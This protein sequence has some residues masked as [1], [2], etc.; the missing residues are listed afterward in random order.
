MMQKKSKFE[1]FLALEASA[2]SGK[3]FALSVRFVAI[4][5]MGQNINNILALTFTNKAAKEMK[6]RIV[7]LFVGL[8]KKENDEYLY[9]GELE[10]LKKLLG[11]DDTAQ[12]IALRDKY[13]D[14]FL[15]EELRVGTFDSF[16]IKILRSFAPNVGLSPDFELCNDNDT[17]DEFLKSLDEHKC[18]SLALHLKWFNL[19]FDS[20]YSQ[21]KTYF[22]SGAKDIKFA[23]LTHKPDIK[24]AL[25]NLRVVVKISTEKPLQA[26]HLHNSLDK[27][28]DDFSI[29]GATFLDESKVYV[30][31]ALEVPSFKKAFDELKAQMLDFAKDVFYN[32]ISFVGD[33]I[34]VFLT[35][36][37]NQIKQTNTLSFSDVS[38]KV[39]SL[40]QDERFKE[41]LNFRLNMQIDHLL[42]DEFQDTNIIQFNILKPLASEILSGVGV[43][44]SLRSLF[45]VGDKKQSIYRFRGGN[46]ETF[47]AFRQD[48]NGEFLAQIKSSS[49]DTNYRS[50]K[51]IV[52][53]VND[54]FSKLYG[55][56]GVDFEL[57]KANKEQDGC[58]KFIKSS[59]DESFEKCLCVINELM[60]YN[61]SLDDI[62]ILTRKNKTAYE[63]KV[64][65]EQNGIKATTKG[66]TL[67]VNE[68]SVRLLLE[69]AKWCVFGD[70]A[71]EEFVKQSIKGAKR[72]KVSNFLDYALNPSQTYEICQTNEI[73]QTSDICPKNDESYINI[74]EN[75][76][77]VY[78]KMLKELK[79][80]TNKHLLEFISWAS[81]KD[82]FLST[83]FSECDLLL[84]SEFSG[85]KIMTV[86]SSKGLQFKNVII[87]DEVRKRKSDSFFVDY[88]FASN[89]FLPIFRGGIFGFLA[90]NDPYFSSIYS[91]FEHKNALD[92]LNVA[93]VAATRAKNNLIFIYLDKSSSY[94][95]L[96]LEDK[97]DLGEFL[98]NKPTQAAFIPPVKKINLAKIPKQKAKPSS[99]V[100]NDSIKIGLCFHYYMELSDFD[101]FSEE[102][103]L[104]VCDEF[105]FYEKHILD[106]VKKSLLN[107]F[108]N[109]EF[110]ALTKGAKAYKE[111]AFVDGDENMGRIDLLLIKDNVAYVIDY[112]TGDESSSYTK[113]LEF[114]KAMVDRYLSKTNEIYEIKTLIL[115]ALEE[116]SYL[117]TL[118]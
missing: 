36:L 118:N 114:Y 77:L 48:E 23:K 75:A 67:L 47:D 30:Q 32:Q 85:V 72:L 82:D 9:K 27:D 3:T 11:I 50:D 42:I 105:R 68:P 66:D 71:Y 5:L 110:L 108:G 104:L 25:Q 117:K 26:K 92:E 86:H 28:Y 7:G 83:L 107:V 78:L 38:Y 34:E 65:L 10:E 63:L 8:D 93:Y 94:E 70:R 115:Y 1:N 79:L 13:L 2:G 62:C 73:Y 111:Y 22:I 20:F 102:L 17:K 37:Q 76:G 74:D 113:Q 80:K 112:K 15:N 97:K 84:K 19:S 60:E 4:V 87:F 45:Y 24:T 39:Y 54:T 69:Y 56:F 88:S 51:L 106:R 61:E 96:G 95:I 81:L 109:D 90:D 18:K 59:K 103:F 29:F 41:L 12:I 116:K 99:F 49:L 43:K 89:S 58:V 40:M 44:D 55:D 35:S 6:E 21:V 52:E 33:M 101:S 98:Q 14:N 64:F 100:D 31:K 53:Y 57:A 91:T 16:F 46:S